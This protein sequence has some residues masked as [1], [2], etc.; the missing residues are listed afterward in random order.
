M[1][2]R[3][4]PNQDAMIKSFL[5]APDIDDAADDADWNY[6]FLRPTPCSSDF[7]KSF[8]WF[9]QIISSNHSSDFLKSFSQIIQVIFSNHSPHT[10]KKINA[11][12]WLPQDFTS[13][14][15]VWYSFNDSP[16]RNIYIYT[17]VFVWKYI[18]RISDVWKYRGIYRRKKDSGQQVWMLKFCLFDLQPRRCL[19]YCAG[20]RAYPD[21]N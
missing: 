20:V 19:L 12:M 16:S 5:N 13:P 2:L 1:Y 18:H 17:Y 15:R 7:I 14:Q 6:G 11:C 21:G 10:T 9:S 4:N 8:K 3:S